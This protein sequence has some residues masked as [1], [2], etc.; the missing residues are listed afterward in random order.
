M[1]EAHPTEGDELVLTDVTLNKTVIG[2]GLPT[3]TKMFDTDQRFDE[4]NVTVLEV[5]DVGLVETDSKQ[6]ILL[7]KPDG[8]TTCVEYSGHEKICGSAGEPLKATNSSGAHQY[9]TWHKA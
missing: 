9:Y 5:K 7:E 8:S 1:E 6:S 2:T 3:G 4:Y